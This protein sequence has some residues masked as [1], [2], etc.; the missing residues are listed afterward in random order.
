MNTNLQQTIQVLEIA[1]NAITELEKELNTKL[2]DEL[3]ELNTKN[4]TLKINVSRTQYDNECE[5][6]LRI[7]LG[8][9]CDFAKLEIIKTTQDEFKIKNLIEFC[10]K[11]LRVKNEFSRI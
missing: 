6:E 2:N 11:Y 3:S 4:D 10:E 8:I 9:S 1:Y 5:N 7:T